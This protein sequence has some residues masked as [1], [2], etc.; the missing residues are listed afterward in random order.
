MESIYWVFF[1]S[2]KDEYV[3]N[4]FWGFRKY[5]GVGFFIGCDVYLGLELVFFFEKEIF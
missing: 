4:F 5:L 2:L 3:R 1:W